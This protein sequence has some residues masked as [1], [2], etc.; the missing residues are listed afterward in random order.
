M[1][2]VV[3]DVLSTLN[4]HTVFPT[5]KDHDKRMHQASLVVLLLEEADA[6]PLAPVYGKDDVL[7]IDIWRPQKMSPDA[8]AVYCQTLAMTEPQLKDLRTWVYQQYGR[9]VT[10]LQICII[11][12]QWQVAQMAD[13]GEQKSC[14]ASRGCSV[15]CIT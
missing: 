3:T 14:C 1:K 5:L 7:P 12:L 2:A 6:C 15:V 9:N 13:V 10:T 11:M 4:L 8:T